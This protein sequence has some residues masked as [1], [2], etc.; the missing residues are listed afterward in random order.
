MEKVADAVV[1]EF[2]AL[3]KYS[4]PRQDLVKGITKFY[5]PGR[6]VPGLSNSSA[7]PGISERSLPLRRDTPT[8][9]TFLLVAYTTGNSR[10]RS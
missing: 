1:T 2:P 9:A 10:N 4:D 3:V 5:T 6:N 8:L 7:F